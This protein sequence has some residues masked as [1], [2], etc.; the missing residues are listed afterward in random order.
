M[1]IKSKGKKKLVCK[2]PGLGAKEMAQNT[3]S[4]SRE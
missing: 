4:S 3:C 1:Y 2:N